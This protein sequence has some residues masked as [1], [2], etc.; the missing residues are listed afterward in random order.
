MFFIHT[1]VRESIFAKT[2]VI[3][4]TDEDLGLVQNVRFR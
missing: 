4:P 2:A 1:N 3:K